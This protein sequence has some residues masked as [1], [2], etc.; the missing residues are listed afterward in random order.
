MAQSLPFRIIGAATT[1]PNVICSEPCKLTMLCAGNIND[2]EVFLKVY[3]KATA[4]DETDTPK[5]TFPIP[6][7]TRGSGSNVPLPNDGIRF[8]RGLSIRM[9]TGLAD[10]DTGATQANEQVVNGA[11]H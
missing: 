9:T 4:P 10:N 2:Q 3:D 7:N 1:N 11:F 5:F 8:E 6:G